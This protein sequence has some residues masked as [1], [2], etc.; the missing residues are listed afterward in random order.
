MVELHNKYGHAV[1]VAPN[2]V[3]FNSAQSLKDIYGARA[4]HKIFLKGEFYSGGSFAGIGTSSIVSERKPEVHKEMRS[5]LAGAFSERSVLEQEPI[6]TASVDKF[7]K[8]IGVRGSEPGGIDF[9]ATLQWMTFDITGDLSFGQAF[10]ALDNEKSHPWIAISLNALKQG[11]LVDV[12][13]RYPILAKIAPVIF[14]G[15]L[16]KLTKDTRAN[17][18]LS[19]ECVRRRIERK[20]ER[21]DFL[22]RI[23][24]DRDPKVVT[25]RQIAAHASD[26]IIAGSDTTTTGIGCM[27]YYLLKDKS[28]MSK[29]TS[30]VREAFRNYEDITYTSTT[31]LKYLRAVI[32]EGLRM[33]S[34]LPLGTPR[35]V[36]EGGDTVDGYYLPGGV[37]VCT[38]PFAASLS[39]DNFHDPW[40]FKPER[41][42]GFNG[43]DNLEA[44][45]PWLIGPRSCMGRNLAW[46]EVRITLSKLVWM[47]DFELVNPSFDWHAESR[48]HTLWVKPKMMVRV[49]HK[50]VSHDANNQV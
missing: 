22:T 40:S 49:K 43:R 16:K 4:G 1:R 26:L 6:V 18:E 7:I 44:S 32:L 11:E 9:P 42:I 5:Y 21:K 45:Q 28:V 36:P 14:S 38:N 41:W 33:Y 19:Y 39:P 8:L 12:L 25:D 27:M 2:D 46:L 48:M 13:N 17:E 34:P 50:E 30:E 35:L 47:Y 29:L 3:S 20:T 15:M 37:T 23:L 24:E 10:G 31:S